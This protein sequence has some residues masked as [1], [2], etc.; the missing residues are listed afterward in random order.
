[1]GPEP[2]PP[3]CSWCHWPV[4]LVPAP[5]GTPEA[6]PAAPDAQVRQ[7]ASS[8]ADDDTTAL[9]PPRVRQCTNPWCPTRRAGFGVAP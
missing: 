6:T 4:R 9:E 8:A 1:M 2:K 7:P 5:P 3:P